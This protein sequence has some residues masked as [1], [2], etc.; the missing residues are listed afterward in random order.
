MGNPHN[1][2]RNVMASMPTQVNKARKSD[3]ITQTPERRKTPEV[4][5]H[6]K[7]I[8]EREQEHMKKSKKERKD[9]LLKYFG[10]GARVPAPSNTGSP[11]DTVLSRRE[12][13]E[14]GGSVVTI[15]RR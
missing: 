6:A 13:K 12:T 5:P 1:I 14:K 2:S 4:T 9:D 7:K 11:I 10:E 8:T 3:K 15:V